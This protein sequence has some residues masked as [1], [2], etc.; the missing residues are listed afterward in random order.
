MIFYATKQ[1]MERYKLK[2]PETMETEMKAVAQIIAERK[3]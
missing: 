3:R 1:M 2:T